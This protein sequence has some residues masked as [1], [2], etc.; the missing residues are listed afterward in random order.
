MI[1][2]ASWIVEA[3][4]Q[5]GRD[6][7]LVA[8][9]SL[10][11]DPAAINLV[12]APH[13][14]YLLSNA[15]DAEID[16]SARISV[17]VCT[18]QPG[19]PWFEIT[20]LLCQSSPLVFDINPQGVDA[21]RDRGFDVRYLRL[22][23][24]PSMDRRTRQARTVD[25]LFLGGLT[26]HRATTLAALAPVLADL[27]ADLRLFDPSQPVD[28]TISSLVFGREKYDLL[29]RSR[30]LL[31]VHR[32]GT[33]SDL[34]SSDYFEWARMVEAMANGCVV[35]SEP[36]VGVEP[37]VPG[38]HFVETTDLAH[39]VSELVADPQRR[40]QIADAAATAVLEQYPLSASL[41]DVLADVPLPIAPSSVR[42][43]PNYRSQMLRTQQIPLLPAF[44]PAPE[45]RRRVI[46][47]LH[48]EMQLQRSIDALRCELRHGDR[49]HVEFITS[50]SFG[51]ATPE[52]SVL[53][54]L[55]NYAALVVE[56]LTSIA[57]STEVDIEIIVVDDHST[58]GGRDVVR[59]FIETNPAVALML[60][61]VDAN[62]GLPA[63]RNLAIEYSRAD[64]VMVMDAD[65]HLYPGAL[66]RLADAL[67]AHADAAFSWSILEE[68]G[69]TTGL[70]SA[71]GW[72]VPW[73]CA[74]NHIDAQAMFRKST[75]DRFGGYRTNDA[76]VFGWEDWEMWLRLADA[77]EYGVHVKQILG[78]YRT[79]TS[80]MLATSNLFGDVMIEHLHD[81]YPN[82]PW[83][84]DHH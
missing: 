2:I 16:A 14:L 66:R 64:K 20:C 82:L 21:L 53:V 4:G 62:Q 78:R 63:S 29:A 39:A 9:G 42:R 1:D 34:S 26:H 12:V 27:N 41:A 45:L 32:G 75:F 60:V 74:A 6:A 81:L 77:G 25:V 19:T 51:Q 40:D 58:D 46:G 61:G 33:E 70:R 5:L 47:A 65:N 79:Q 43:P 24:V 38:K 8:D 52:V 48:G 83:P 55:Y 44:R 67:D 68:F 36:S 50:P 69:Q 18:E 22:G 10:P 28:S 17:P 72:H 15:S 54:T 3:A 49:R 84:T 11:A 37:L 7:S 23:A 31:N 35:V 13:E 56:T 80:S 30:I 71:T 57:A 59:Q 76:L 73:L